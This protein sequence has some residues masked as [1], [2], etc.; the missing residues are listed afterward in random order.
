[1]RI[2]I[3][4]GGTFTDVVMIDDASGKEYYTK[5]ST[6]P[7]DLWVGVLNGIDK[8]LELAGARISD[9]EYIVHGTT[10][11]TNALIERKGA[12][13]G[14]ITTAGFEDV[15]EIGRIQRPDAGLYNVNIDNPAPLV[16]RRWRKGVVERVAADGSVVTALDEQS[17]RKAVQELKAAGV[18][19]IVVSLLFSFLN[20]THERRIAEIIRDIYP[21]AYVS[22]S[23]DLAPEFREYERTSTAVIN[24]YLQPIMKRYLDR[25]TTELDAQYGKVDLRIMQASG[26]TM[27]VES[28]KVRAINTVNSGPA[29]GT[30]AAA[31]IGQTTDR[32]RLIAVDM[33][34]TSFDISVT[35]DGQPKVTAMGKLEGLPVRIPIIEVDTIG[36]GGGSLAWI[37]RGGALNMGPESAGARPG[38]ACYGRGGTRPTCTDA[39]LVLGKLDPAYFLGGEMELDVAAA[40]EAIRKHVADPLG[41]TVEEA[42]AGIIRVINAKMA[43]G[44]KVNSV[45]K[46][47]DLREFTLVSFGG[48]ASVHSVELAAELGIGVVIMP[49]MAGNLSAFGLLVADAR[50]DYVQT[51]MKKV[52]DLTAAEL[53]E[54]YRNMESRGVAALRDEGFRLNDIVP[55][56]TA[57]LRY[58]GQ[59]YELNVPVARTPSAEVDLGSI[60]AAFHALHRRRYAYSSESEPVEL[61]NLRVAAIGRTPAIRMQ[62]AALAGPEPDGPAQ[63]G[64][65]K[66]YFEGNGFVDAGVYERDR[67]KPG[68][69]ILGPA[70]VEER[71][72]ALS[73]PP[74]WTATVDE[75]R[76]IIVTAEGR[77]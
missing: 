53:T 36:A 33:G 49:P 14:L 3:D 8:I 50:H 72:S 18:E 20:P 64:T 24:A 16:P 55:I 41:L 35:E 69:R 73:V 31:F 17:V 60:V 45:Q 11:G 48:A 6:T 54:A 13:T 59:A 68:N 63:K 57:D 38:P 22:L 34:G 47:L 74:G 42:A 7:P 67:L 65:R 15:L 71:I 27:T 30:M 2:G 4:V 40:R 29:G 51:V 46:G 1:M 61:V 44:I 9:V 66:V 12:R 25:L 70:I 10:I 39:N 77:R 52:G 28:A 26:G 76:N 32:S 43:K 37:D 56:W 23:S 19:S 21:E 5:V 75:Y 58:E 62:R